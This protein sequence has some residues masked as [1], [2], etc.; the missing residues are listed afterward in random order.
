MCG[1]RTAGLLNS[2]LCCHGNTQIPLLGQGVN[3]GAYFAH[4][5]ADEIAHSSPSEEWPCSPVAAD[6]GFSIHRKPLFVVEAA[7]YGREKRVLLRE[8]LEQG[9]S[10]PPWRRSWR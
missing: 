3:G 6:G 7:M 9:S 5:M 2:M 10:R 1:F 4:L 8:Y